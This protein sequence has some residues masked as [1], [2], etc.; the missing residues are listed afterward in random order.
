MGAVED[1][2]HVLYDCPRYQPLRDRFHIP[3]A[4]QVHMFL[5][6]TARQMGGFVKAALHLREQPVVAEERE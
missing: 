2:V 4:P 6:A 5:P 1:E 3:I